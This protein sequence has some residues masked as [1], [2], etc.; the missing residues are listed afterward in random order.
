V[1]P[2]GMTIRRMTNQSRG[3][4]SLMGPYLSRREIV[5]DVGGPIWDDDGKVWYVGMAHGMVLGFAAAADRGSWVQLQ[6]AYT[7]PAWR[8]HGVYRR[9]LDA[10][11]E[12]YAGRAIRATC[13]TA[14]LPALLA[15]GFT[16]TSTRGAFT[17]VARDG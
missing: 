3:F 17:R 9:L 10:R 1:G 14:S 2:D 8:R 16:V 7:L 13:T 6:S 5:A 11:L 4:Y 15:R 12:D